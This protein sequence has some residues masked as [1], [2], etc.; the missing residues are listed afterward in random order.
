M[1]IPRYRPVRL[2]HRL[3][4][5]TSASICIA[6][7]CTAT[8]TAAATASAPSSLAPLVTQLEPNDGPPAGGTAVTI[9]GANFSEASTVMFGSDDAESFTVNSDSSITAVSPPQSG[10]WGVVDVTVTGPGGTSAVGPQDQFGYGP[11]VDE[12]TPHQGPAIGGTSITLTGF[13]LQGATAVDFGPSPAL[14]FS[15][16]SDGSITA[17]S[18]PVT[19]GST[20]VS[21][22]VTTPEG[23]SNTYYAPDTEPANFFSYGPT[24]TS[25]A[26][27]EGPESGGT[28]VTIHGS[29]FTSSPILFRCL[30]GPFVNRVEFGS[31]KLECGSPLGPAQSPCAPV[32]FTVISDTEIIATAPP[33]TGTVD[34]KVVTAGGSSPTE[35][36]D[37]FTYSPLQGIPDARSAGTKVQLVKCRAVVT[38]AVAKATQSRG[39]KTGAAKHI[40]TSKLV[41]APVGTGPLAARLA[42]K[43][44]L[45]ATGTAA[46]KAA[47]TQLVLNPVR[48]VTP[49]RYSLALSSRS[50]KWHEMLDIR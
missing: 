49:G 23:A 3:V 36:S 35:S 20:L 30:C 44:L 27:G 14:S 16:N 10:Y 37:L 40:C 22:T 11:I 9:T 4:V 7:A 2:R 21:V 18:P 43:G 50:G 17:V 12:M 5:A 46:V 1:P 6:M 26:P 28:S 8:W 39:R 32:N 33:G 29:G 45:Y 19:A 42:R 41:S 48:N 24:V 34:V 25:V 38:G 31:T 15:E 13:G 47:S